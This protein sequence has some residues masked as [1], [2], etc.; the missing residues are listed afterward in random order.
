MNTKANCIREFCIISIAFCLGMGYIYFCTC[1]NANKDSCHTL[2]LRT[3]HRPLSPCAGPGASEYGMRPFGRTTFGRTHNKSHQR[4]DRFIPPGPLALLATA[5]V[6][7]KTA[8]IGAGVQ[9]L[10]STQPCTRLNM[11]IC[12]SRP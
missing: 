11:P 3:L 6:A 9:E 1:D 2:I 10:A 7:A 5:E 12:P 4:Y 8:A